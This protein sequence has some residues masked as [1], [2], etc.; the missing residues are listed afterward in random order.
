MRTFIGT[1]LFVLLASCRNFGCRP[2]IV[3]TADATDSD[4]ADATSATVDG[5]ALRIV[6]VSSTTGGAPRTSFVAPTERM[7]VR[8]QVKGKPELEREVRWEVKPL[9]QHTGPPRLVSAGGKELLFEGVSKVEQSG[10]RKPNPPLE[11][12]VVARLQ[13]SGNTLE[14]RMPTTSRIRQDEADVLR[15][16]YFDYQTQFRPALANVALSARAT[17]NT[18]NYEVI[19]EEEPGSLEA[20]L[21]EVT[22]QLNRLLNNDVQVQPVGRRGLAA[23]ALVV[24]PGAPIPQVGAMGDTDPQGDDVC[25]GPLVRGRCAGPIR[26][27]PNGV[28]ETRANNRRTQADLEPFIT[29]AFRNPQRNRAVGSASVNSRHTRGRALDINPLSMAIAGK[30][31]SQMMCLVEAAGA[32]VVGE[33]NSFTERGATTFLDC[34]SPA[35]DHVHIQR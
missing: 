8:A 34:D 20:L 13:V 18:G 6:E 35:A 22:T 7:R 32:A 23:T 26:A 25:A 31:P 17:F 15:Q 14:A 1:C 2:E 21:R 3:D 12:E 27:G 16:E 28:A 5:L 33:D 24:T 11:Y 30:T 10:S 19:A 4:A 29:S 9:G